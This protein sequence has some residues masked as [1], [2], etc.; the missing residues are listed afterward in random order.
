MLVAKMKGNNV[1]TKVVRRDEYVECYVGRGVERQ[2]VEWWSSTYA[3]LEKGECF[4]Q[5]E[6]LEELLALKGL[7]PK[8]MEATV[9]EMLG[10]ST[11][12]ETVNYGRR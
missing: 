8:L 11:E 3:A 6:T 12:G 9:R 5:D 4:I 1:S 7:K 10:A 2:S